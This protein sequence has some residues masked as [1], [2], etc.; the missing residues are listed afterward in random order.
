MRLWASAGIIAVIILVGFVLSVPHA[1][2]VPSSSANASAATSTPMVTVHDSYRKGVH[3]IT[4]SVLAPDAC[5]PVSVEAM[6]EGGVASPQGILLAL[7]MRGDTGVCL[8][9]PTRINISTTILAPAS[10]PIS[11]TVNGAAASTTSS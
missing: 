2:E 5:T 6:V 4:G 11:V 8:E 1:R 7:T 3:T 9:V 10:L